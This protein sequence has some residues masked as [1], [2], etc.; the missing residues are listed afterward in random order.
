ML[1]LETVL[2]TRRLRRVTRLT[3]V[4][5]MLVGNYTAGNYTAGNYTSGSYTAVNN[6]TN[7][8][9]S[10]TLPISLATGVYPITLRRTV[11][12]PLRPMF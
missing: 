8:T 3:V 12:V 6:T 9:S 10:A 11:A 5:T 7:S 4:E 2:V 1:A